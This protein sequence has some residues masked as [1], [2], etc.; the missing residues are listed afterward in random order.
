MNMSDQQYQPQK[1]KIMHVG[2]WVCCAVML[3]PLLAFFAR[4]GTLSGLQD[5]LGVFAPIV[6]C[7]A[8]HGVML[9]FMGKSCHGDRKTSKGDA[10][11]AAKAPVPTSMDA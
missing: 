3:L 8:A 6:L 2:M 1:S 10:P 5:S 9:F 11:V 7:L 4:G